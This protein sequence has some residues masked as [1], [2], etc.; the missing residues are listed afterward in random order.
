MGKHVNTLKEQMNNVLAQE[1]AYWR[2]RRS[3][4]GTG[5]LGESGL[6]TSVA[7][8]E[9]PKFFHMTAS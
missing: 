6:C 5:R 9:C 2:Q 1:E 4:E 7:L 8:M 3:L